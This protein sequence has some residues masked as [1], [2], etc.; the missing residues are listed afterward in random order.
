MAMWIYCFIRRLTGTEIFITL[1]G[2][3]K[4]AKE[5]QYEL[6]RGYAKIAFYITI[7][8]YFALTMDKIL[9][10]QDNSLLDYYAEYSASSHLPGVVVKV[11]DCYLIA[12]MLFLATRPSK[13]ETLLPMF[14]FL[15]ASALTLL[16]GVRNV[17]ILNIIF[18]V[19]YFVIRNGD[20]EEIWLPKRYVVIGLALLPVA[21]VLLQAFDVFRRNAG[22]SLEDLKELFSFTL[23]KDFFVSQ[24]VSSDI[25]PYAMKYADKLGGQPVPYT[26]GTLYTYLRQN[27]IVRFFTGAASFTSN[28]VESALVGGNLGARMAYHMFRDSFLSGVGMGGSYTAELFVDFS[29]PGVFLGTML[30]C[31]I[32]NRLS[33]AA[34]RRG[35]SPFM[36]A[37]ALVAVRWMAYLPRDSYFAWAMQAFSF[38]NILFILMMFFLSHFQLTVSAGN[39][40]TL[41][42]LKA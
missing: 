23:V 10:R 12:F 2:R 26:L 34:V 13:R 32:M 16:Y 30:A 6:I 42:Q 3:K 4:A 20:G 11:A 24:S 27:M 8:A 36:L 5:Y 38:M 29:Y 41:D 18:A 7:M 19:I 9:Y 17:F 33:K 15:M 39:E 25:L 21:M 14:L 37:F 31:G 35:G 40:E 1:N 28:S 22:F